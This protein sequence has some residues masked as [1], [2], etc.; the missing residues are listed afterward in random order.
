LTSAEQTLHDFVLDLLSND[1][2]RSAFGADP[3]AALAGAGLHDVTPQDVQEVVPLVM[4]YAP[5]GLSGLPV[6]GSADSV[7]QQLQAVAQVGDAQGSLP[8]ISLP[9]SEQFGAGIG[10]ESPFGDYELGAK[11]TPDEGVVG[12]TQFTGNDLAAESGIGASGNGVTV[13][14]I[15]HSA[16]GDFGFA[17]DGAPALTVP[18]AGLP[19]FDSVT[20]PT[21][22][23]DTDVSAG[24]VASYVSAGGE[25]FA[26]TVST[27]SATLGGYLTGAG[28]PVGGSVTETGHA[29]A[30]GISD[31]A[32][33]VADHVP[34]LPVPDA[35]ALPGLPATPGLPALPTLPTLPDLHNGLQGLPDV[36]SQLPVH[37]PTHLPVELPHLPIANP[38]PDLGNSPVQSPLGDAASHSPLGE[39]ASPDHLS[40]LHPVD[41]PIDLHL[42]H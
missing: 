5:S 8:R 39:V 42:G 10:G 30:A 28:I 6:A 27:T 24:T 31:G 1:T 12:I 21:S 7:I 16:L 29:A 36:T 14:A 33:S 41:A 11:I 26:G 17:S 3:T 9:N 20:D 37:L 35:G 40:L 4:D 22:A 32:T 13:N 34:S 18:G 25:V 38:L 15:T 19:R 2:A 23:L